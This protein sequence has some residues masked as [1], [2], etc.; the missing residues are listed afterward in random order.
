MKII[1]AFLVYG[2]V[3]SILNNI[4]MEKSGEY[5]IYTLLNWPVEHL[6]IPPSLLYFAND[7]GDALLQDQI[8]ILRTVVSVIFWGILGFTIHS[9]R[10]ILTKN[11][12]KIH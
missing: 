11:T 6:F 12:I 4:S 10:R 3:V 7:M 9:I 1:I 5:I 2:F 8:M